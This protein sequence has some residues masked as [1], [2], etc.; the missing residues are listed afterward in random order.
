MGKISWL[1]RGI[2]NVNIYLWVTSSWVLHKPCSMIKKK[3]EKV[4]KE[5]KKIE[6]RDDNVT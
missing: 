6:N 1:E 5:R 4:E 2:N 3:R